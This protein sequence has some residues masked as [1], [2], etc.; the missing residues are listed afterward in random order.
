MLL[1]S[2]LTVA[3]LALL[4]WYAGRA[5]PADAQL[6]MHW[7]AAGEIDRYGDKWTALM[8]PVLMAAIT[9]LLFV[10]VSVAEPQRENL[11]K[12]RG[13]LNVAWAGILGLS[14][15]IELMIV[16]VAFHGKVDALPILFGAIGFF[17]M[18]L[19]N[20]LSKSRPTYMVGIRT[21][22]T[23]ADPDIWIATHR[24]GGKLMM[25]A[26]LAWLVC[27]VAGWVNPLTVPFLVVGMLAAS[28]VPVV[29]SYLLWRRMGK[30]G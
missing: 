7:N 4:A 3:G 5:L 18:L 23:L 29:Y 9:S 1:F 25:I 8:I 27:A 14:V 2:A 30:R 13:L 11:E 17:F 20:Q 10:G 12:S 6:P 16:A 15:V 28:L 26:G 22:W 19:G 24:L 21:P